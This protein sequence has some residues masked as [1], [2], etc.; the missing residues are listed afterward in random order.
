MDLPTLRTPRLLLKPLNAPQAARLAELADDP[1]VR[2]FTANMPSPYTVE[3]AHAFIERSRQAAERD[4][5]Y[6]AGIHTHAGELMGVIN[7]RPS[8]RHRSGHLGYWIGAAF[9]NQGFTTEAVRHLMLFAFQTLEL[10]RVHTAC[11]ATNSASARVL[12]K[13]GLAPEGRSKQAFL[14]DGVFHDLLLFGAVA[15][16]WPRPAP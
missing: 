5:D 2:A 13:A 9:R 7:L 16:T 1:W 14:K 10:H 4:E 11:L 3:A 8:R 15:A 12:E 6:V